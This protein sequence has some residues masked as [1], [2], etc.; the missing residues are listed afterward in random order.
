MWK[1]TPLFGEWISAPDNALFKDGFLDSNS[2]VIELGCGI[3][4]IIGLA[5]APKIRRYF[6]TDQDYVLKLL[7]ENIEENERSFQTASHKGGRSSRKTDFVSKINCSTLDWETNSQSHLYSEL[8]LSPED[9]LDLIIACDCI[10][11]SHLV[12]PLVNTCA[13]ICRL[14]PATEPT[15][16]VIAQQLRSAEVFEEWLIEFHKYFRIWR[17][18]D[19]ILTEDLK[20]GQG[21]VIHFGILRSSSDTSER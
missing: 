10:Y 4:G 11:N 20:E 9:N 19:A 14:A 6:A 5:L 2:Y 7:R 3:S 13:E 8:G 18:P 16:C 17:V 21:F 12:Q 1:I 15:L